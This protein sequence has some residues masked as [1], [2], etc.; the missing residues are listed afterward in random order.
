[1]GFFDDLAGDVAKNIIDP[2]GIG[3]KIV[4]ETA[5]SAAGLFNDATAPFLAPIQNIM[6]TLEP[7]FRFDFGDINARLSVAT[8]S[9]FVFPQLPSLAGAGGGGDLTGGLLSDLAFDSEALRRA[10][11]DLGFLASALRRGVYPHRED[12]FFLGVSAVPK[13]GA[14]SKFNGQVWV[15]AHVT[16]A[17]GGTE[18][19]VAVGLR[20][21]EIN[22][23]VDSTRARAGGAQA[24]LPVAEMA[25][26][27]E[28][29]SMVQ[30]RTQRGSRRIVRVELTLQDVGGAPLANVALFLRELSVWI[31]RRN[32]G[33]TD[34]L[35]SFV[36]R[37]PSGDR[38]TLV[39]PV[40]RIEY[41]SD[42]ADNKM[43]AIGRDGGGLAGAAEAIDQALKAMQEPAPL[44]D[45]GK[46]LD[47]LQ[48]ILARRVSRAEAVR[49]H[50]W[51]A[52]RRIVRLQS[53]ENVFDFRLRYK[54]RL[55]NTVNSRRTITRLRMRSTG[56][57]NADFDLGRF[58]LP[59]HSRYDMTVYPLRQ[60]PNTTNEATL[61]FLDQRSNF[62]MS[63]VAG[64]GLAE[65]VVRSV[66]PTG[67]GVDTA[68][69]DTAKLE[70]S[71]SDTAG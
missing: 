6:K 51:N 48:G 12:A 19:D 42:N 59:P 50:L 69:V 63:L 39:F 55:E 25:A 24:V 1:M 60:D 3:R 40:D 54:L 10:E 9:E 30:L 20:D 57:P 18:A 22:E 13:L 11:T 56:V 47:R 52:K 46:G 14:D 5:K 53:T 61:E 16:N 43:Q 36:W 32:D 49:E 65:S 23:R 27:F 26:A 70:W 66:F 7:G 33:Y 71:V 8:R 67:Q 62:T 15:R 29:S 58:E 37:E 35:H 21:I 41:I 17:D 4:S 45:N 28:R 44:D 31:E 38:L 64:L 34:V 68:K 2:G